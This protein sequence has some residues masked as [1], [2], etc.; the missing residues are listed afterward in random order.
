MESVTNPSKYVLCISNEGCDDLHV[1]QVYRML[2]D[3]RSERAGLIRIVD[4]SGEDYLYPK[5]NFAR[6]SIAQHSRDSVQKV[7]RNGNAESH[8]RVTKPKLAKTK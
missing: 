8:R 3:P 7:F 1:R 2:P 4:E 6:I 5:G